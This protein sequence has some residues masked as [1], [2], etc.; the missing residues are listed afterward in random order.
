MVNQAGP[1]QPQNTLTEPT[2]TGEQAQL[3]SRSKPSDKTNITVP[4]RWS[5]EDTIPALE[6][7]TDIPTPR[8]QK[9]P[10]PT[11]KK[12]KA[13]RKARLVSYSSHD[14]SQDDTA[15]RK[16][17][18]KRSAVTKMGGVTI[19]CITTKHDRAEGK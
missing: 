11:D 3:E 8:D 1:S 5:D 4:D 19:D 14:D 18:R 16:N 12:K 6:G 17:G 10:A 9:M 13:P 7:E 2:A 15:S